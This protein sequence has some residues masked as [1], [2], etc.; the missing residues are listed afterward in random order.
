[1]FF[2]VGEWLVFKDMIFIGRWKILLY[3]IK[4]YRLIKYVGKRIINVKII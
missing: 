2:K 4:W 3:I 1:M